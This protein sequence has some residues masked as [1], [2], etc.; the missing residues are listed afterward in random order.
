MIV[1]DVRQY[2]QRMPRLHRPGTL[3]EDSGVYDVVDEHG[4]FLNLQI[5]AIE[6]KPFPMVDHP[7]AKMFI[8]HIKTEHLRKGISFKPGES[9]LYSGI[10]DVVN[11]NKESIGRQVTCMAGDPFPPIK[12][13]IG[14]GYVLDYR[15]RYAPNISLPHEKV[16]KK[17]TYLVI[18]YEG[19]DL[20]EKVTLEAGDEFP[21]FNDLHYFLDFNEWKDAYGYVR[22]PAGPLPRGKVP[23]LPRTHRPGVK[24]KY[25]G[26]YD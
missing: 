7:R 23:R 17:G 10:Y 18:D 22:E 25:S 12:D 14:E 9:V 3:V 19:L 13:S 4:R 24:V 5:M 1:S 16:D 20:G 8:L 21:A 11:G 26:V 6:N 15:A 2:V